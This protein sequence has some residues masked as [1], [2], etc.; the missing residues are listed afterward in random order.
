MV[1][2]DVS[3]KYF[4]SFLLPNYNNEN[5]LNL[6]FEKF[7]QNNTYSHYEFIFIDDGSLDKSLD[8]AFK[9]KK[10][11]YIKNIKI[12][13]LE[14]VGICKALNTG[15]KEV[16]GDFIIRMDGDATVETKSFVEKF[17]KF[18][19][20]NPSKI[21]VI[22]SKVIWETGIVHALG[23]NVI[24]KEGLHNRGGQVL[25]PIGKRTFDSIVA[26]PK[27]EECGLCNLIAEVDT[28]LGVLTF[29]DAEIAFKIG[30]FDE[31]YPLWIEDDDF[32]LSFRLYNKKVFFL[33]TVK[34]IHRPSL[35]GSRNPNFGNN[36]LSFQQYVKKLLPGFVISILKKIKKHF[37]KDTFPKETD[38][39]RI[40]ILK[41]DYE[42]WKK[43]WKFD[44]L[45][46]DIEKIIELYKGT[47]L[48]WNFDDD[49]KKEGME[50][51]AKYIEG[52]N[53][54]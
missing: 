28:A 39:W 48:I 35:R 19:E 50:I 20:I 8:V 27:E 52:R 23:R 29:F 40:K 47:E 1:V 54:K 10:S 13:P 3:K 31:N 17:L 5:V 2:S 44:P 21:G 26:M 42:Y 7:I 16:K 25:E 15:L 14:H 22:T 36:K 32:F 4:V 37:S 38:S 34:V 46:P 53:I 18:Y 11:G 45:N 9:W 12:I 41:H 49:M 33:P 24:C 30:C 6:F 43:K 51:I